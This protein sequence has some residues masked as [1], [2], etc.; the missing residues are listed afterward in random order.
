MRRAKR[1]KLCRSVWQAGDILI[2][3]GN[4][5]FKMTCARRQLKEKAFIMWMSAPARRLAWTAAIA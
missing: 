1:A 2:D 3:G 5:Y 4:S